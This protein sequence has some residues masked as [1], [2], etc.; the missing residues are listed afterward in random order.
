MYRPIVLL[1]EDEPDVRAGIATYLALKDY[2]VDEAAGCREAETRFQARRPDIVI[3]DFA[4]EDGN[5][6]DLLAALKRLDPQVPLLVLT[7]HGSIELAVR[8]I[9]EGAEQFL[10]KPVELPIL[11]AMIQRILDSQRLARKAMADSSRFQKGAPDP[12]LGV[13]R[14]IRTLQSQAVKVAQASAP[15]L[16]QGETGV[17]K[18]VLARWIHQNSPRAKEAMVDLN[19]AGLERTFF[20]NELFGHQKGAYTGAGENKMGLLEVGHL[21]TVF[22]DEIGDVDLA[23]QPKLLKVLEENS[24]RRMGDVRDRQVN[25]RLIA[26]T[27]QDLQ[28]MAG[29]KTFRED[30]YYR[31]NTLMLRIPPLRERP[32]DIPLLARTFMETFCQRSG[33]NPVPITSGAMKRLQHYPWPGNIRE[34]KNLVERAAILSDGSAFD[35]QHLL[36]EPLGGMHLAPRRSE[37]RASLEDMERQH[38]EKALE[39][40]HWRVGLAA[41]RLGVPRSTLYFKI[42]K[43]GL[44]EPSQ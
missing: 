37:V 28:A 23:V 6:L 44:R 27:H 32:E 3:C 5:A 15:V 36:A 29:A 2:Q 25:I 12:F 17:G 34:L 14:A 18:G 42:K 22:L 10:T 40:A 33:K 11:H 41:E 7:G 30:L 31:I 13:S 19:C 4:L 24:F 39:E 16:I 43:L 35:E 8:S 26:A 9:K 21:G 1:V 20:E 38:I